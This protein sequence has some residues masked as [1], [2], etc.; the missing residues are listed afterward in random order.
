[1][2]ARFQ[3]SG[4]S[5]TE[6]SWLNRMVRGVHK[7][8]FNCLNKIGGKPSGP[9]LDLFLRLVIDRITSDSLTTIVSKKN[10]SVE[11]FD[12]LVQFYYQT[13]C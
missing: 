9:Q 6:R 2:N 13:I 1:M 11:H 5:P 10:C 7:V 4:T 8:C 12:N 3:A